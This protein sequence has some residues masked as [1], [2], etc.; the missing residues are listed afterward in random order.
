MLYFLASCLYAK[1][2]QTSKNNERETVLDSNVCKKR[3]IVDTHAKRAPSM[4]FNIIREIKI[5]AIIPRNS[6][7]ERNHPSINC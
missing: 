5:D 3:F 4:G 6:I 2:I 7:P 1:N